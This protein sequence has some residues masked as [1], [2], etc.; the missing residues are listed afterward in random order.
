MAIKKS[1]DDPNY[2]RLINRMIT[3][4]TKQ[5]ELLGEGMLVIL[6]PHIECLRMYIRQFLN[7]ST[8]VRLSKR[9]SGNKWIIANMSQGY[10]L[11]LLM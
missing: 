8:S 9:Q 4:L 6:Y 1:S 10:Q 2:I 3:F 7:L 11:H 5:Y